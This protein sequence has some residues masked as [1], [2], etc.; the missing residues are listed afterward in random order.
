MA[1]G[2]TCKLNLFDRPNR[3]PV[4]LLTLASTALCSCFGANRANESYFRGINAYSIL[5]QIHSHNYMRQNT[6]FY[7]FNKDNI[8]HVTQLKQD[9]GECLGSL[10]I[11]H[12]VIFR[13]IPKILNKAVRCEMLAKQVLKPQ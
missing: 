13:S 12:D 6:P 5:W 3:R 8:E 1:G 4:V 7:T 11:K 2:G 9:H 10:S